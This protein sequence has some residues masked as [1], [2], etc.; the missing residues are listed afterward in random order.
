MT[1][2]DLDEA[3]GILVTL[4]NALLGILQGKTAVTSASAKQA[5][6]FLTANAGNQ[7]VA[8]ALGT[9]LFDCFEQV[10]LL[11]VTR[12]QMDTIRILMLSQRPK[13]LAAVAIAISGVYFALVE[14]VQIVAATKFV[15]REDVDA[16]LAALNVAFEP[17]EEFAADATDDPSV[18]QAVVALHS[19]TTRDLIAR[20]RPLPRLV[21]YTFNVNLPFLVLSQRLYATAARANELRDENKVV[22]P[23]FMPTSGRCLSDIV[24]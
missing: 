8:G 20:A 11:G 6:G 3:S 4:L 24:G 18:Y 10:R 7:I 19:S 17:A 16:T 2:N 21:T 23:L 5:I 9:Q 22:H 1:R 13:G 12:Q 15:S 14:E